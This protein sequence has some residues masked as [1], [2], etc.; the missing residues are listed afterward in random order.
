[1][2]IKIRMVQLVFFDAANEVSFAVVNAIFILQ[3]INEKIRQNVKGKWSFE[4]HL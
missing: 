4:K 1:M 2:K 3:K